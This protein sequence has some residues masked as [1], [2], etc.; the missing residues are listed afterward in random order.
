MTT[1]KMIY[2]ITYD[3]NTEGKDYNA[4]Y[5]K[6]KSLGQ[7]FHPLESVWFLQSSYSV[8]QI[9]E[10]LRTTM[11]NN[12]YIFVV[13]ITRQLRQGWLPKTAWEWLRTHE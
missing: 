6:I 9:S 1:L 11:D 2:L 3:L 8:S 10:Q 4:L 5:D 7:W 13:E 12:D